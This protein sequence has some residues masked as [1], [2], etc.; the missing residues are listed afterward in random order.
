MATKLSLNSLDRRIL[1]LND[2][3]AELDCFITPLV[4]ELA[5]HLHRLEGV[6]IASAG[7]LLVTAG[8]DPDRLR[9]EASLAML[10]GACPLPA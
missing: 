10:C 4:E 6:A 5:R 9:S 2:E 3:I 7:E 1:D 8:D